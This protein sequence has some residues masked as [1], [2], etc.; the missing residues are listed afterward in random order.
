MTIIYLD[1][2]GAPNK[3]R[4]WVRSAPQAEPLNPYEPVEISRIG[5]EPNDANFNDLNNLIWLIPDVGILGIHDAD[6]HFTSCTRRWDCL[7]FCG[8]FAT[9]PVDV[10]NWPASWP[11]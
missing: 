9:C 4:A 10:N 1:A 7:D 11:D 8:S 6:R 3:G 5:D 2:T